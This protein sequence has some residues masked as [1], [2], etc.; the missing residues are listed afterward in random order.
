MSIF[1]SSLVSSLGKL[2]EWGQDTYKAA[3]QAMKGMGQDSKY[4][5]STKKGG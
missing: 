3:R 4:F 2:A 5:S 1:Q